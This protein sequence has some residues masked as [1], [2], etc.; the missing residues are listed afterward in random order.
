MLLDIAPSELIGLLRTRQPTYVVCKF[1]FVTVLRGNVGDAVVAKMFSP[2]YGAIN[3]PCRAVDCANLR[4][5]VQD[6]TR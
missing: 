6:S 1:H 3:S 4:F 5:T 2:D